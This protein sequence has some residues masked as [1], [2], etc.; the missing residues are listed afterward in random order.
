[1]WTGEGG[2]EEGGSVKLLVV[3]GGE[4]KDV[5]TLMQKMMKGPMP[6]RNP[7]HPQNLINERRE[8]RVVGRCHALRPTYQHPHTNTH[9]YT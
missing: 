1:V 6:I 2:R 3:V 9:T 4:G 7:Y 5:H 8:E